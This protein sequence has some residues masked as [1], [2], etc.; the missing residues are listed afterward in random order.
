MSGDAEQHRVISFPANDS[1]EILLVFNPNQQNLQSP[2]FVKHPAYSIEYYG[3]SRKLGDG[4]EDRLAR[5][6]RILVFS[7]TGSEM[8]KLLGDMPVKHS[9][10]IQMSREVAGPGAPIRG[11]K[12]VCRYRRSHPA[13][14]CRA[15]PGDRSEH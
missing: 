4:I 2:A 3:Q 13:E 11:E 1:L 7:S 8:A 9:S 15:D 14:G 6:C 12:R 5:Y 10:R